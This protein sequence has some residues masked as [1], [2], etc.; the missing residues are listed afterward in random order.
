MRTLNLFT[1]F[2]AVASI[3]VFVTALVIVIAT[4][5]RSELACEVCAYS[6]ITSFVTLVL[7]Q[8]KGRRDMAL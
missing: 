4:D 1:L 3:A 8:P 7:Y 2:V 6:I 5:G